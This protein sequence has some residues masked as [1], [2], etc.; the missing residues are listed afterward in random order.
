MGNRRVEVRRYP[1]QSKV[2][3]SSPS[4]IALE[5]FD[6]LSDAQLKAVYEAYGHFS[7]KDIETAIKSETSGSLCKAL[8]AIGTPSLCIAR[9]TK[10]SV[11]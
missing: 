4:C 8:L 2:G 10:L 3:S 7:K 6:W 5:K 9:E 11:V 1:L